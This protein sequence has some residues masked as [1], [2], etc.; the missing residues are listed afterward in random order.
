[1]PLEIFQK[2]NKDT[3]MNKLSQ[4]I[5]SKNKNLGSMETNIQPKMGHVLEILFM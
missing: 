5:N 1:M 4:C 2:K 3:L